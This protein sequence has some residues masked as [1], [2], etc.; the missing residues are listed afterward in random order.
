MEG[1]SFE[2]MQRE[3]FR[4]RVESYQAGGLD[5]YADAARLAELVHAA[6]TS[7]LSPSEEAERTALMQKLRDKKLGAQP[8]A[9]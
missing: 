7:A 3:Q 2:R 6:E 8:E 5:E 9:E 1:E 4:V